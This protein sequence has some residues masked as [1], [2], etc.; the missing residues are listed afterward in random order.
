MTVAELLLVTH[1]AEVRCGFVNKCCPQAVPSSVHFL[2]PE[3]PQLNDADGPVRV[4]DALKLVPSTSSR[5]GRRTIWLRMN[6]E[7]RPLG[8][9]GRF[10]ALPVLN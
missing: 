5:P 9:N 1:Q 6:L 7:C 2:V 8:I 3:A 4:L 10:I